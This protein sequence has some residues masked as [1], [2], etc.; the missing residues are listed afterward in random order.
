MSQIDSSLLQKFTQYVKNTPIA[1]EHLQ[2]LLS[3]LGERWF[4]D[5]SR[6]SLVDLERLYWKHV[7]SIPTELSDPE[8][9][10]HLMSQYLG[11]MIVRS[12]GAKW[13]QCKD[14]NP[15]FGQPCLDEFGNKEWDR[16]FPVSLAT[17]FRSLPR[18][19]PD[20]P[21]VRER[22]VLALK[23]DKAISINKKAREG[24]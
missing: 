14:Q 3:N 4:G 19:K 8:H 11:E 7:D 9:L 2:F 21:G 16:F 6:D 13:V 18:N 10:A 5:F 15:L 12:T 24:I 1:V 22:Q 20:F 23:Y 17:H